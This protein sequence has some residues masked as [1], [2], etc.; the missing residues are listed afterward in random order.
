MGLLARSITGPVALGIALVM[1]VAIG[2]GMIARPDVFEF[3]SKVVM[4]PLVLA[5]LLTASGLI[6]TFFPGLVG[7]V[8]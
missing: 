8:V 4:I 6:T 5:I 1:I 2:G 7:A 3:G